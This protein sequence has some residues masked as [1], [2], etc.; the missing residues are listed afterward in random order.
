MMVTS[1]SSAIHRNIYEALRSIST[2]AL[3]VIIYYAWPESGAGEKLSWWS[4]LQAG[5]FVISIVGSFVY[6]RVVKLPGFDYVIENEEESIPRDLVSG[7]EL[8]GG[9]VKNYE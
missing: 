6:N 3:S 7:E 9:N 4:F 1:F 2:W 5:G 8:L